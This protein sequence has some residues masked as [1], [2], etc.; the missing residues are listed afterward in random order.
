MICS[1]CAPYTLDCASYEASTMYAN[2]SYKSLQT[3]YR[4]VATAQIVVSSTEDTVVCSNVTKVTV[5]GAGFF[6]NANQ[7]SATFRSSHDVTTQ[8]SHTAISKNS[9]SELVFEIRCDELPFNDCT[10]SKQIVLSEFTGDGNTQSFSSSTM[11]IA[12]VMCILNTSETY[13]VLVEPNGGLITIQGYN[14]GS[15]ENMTRVDLVD[16]GGTSQELSEA[17]IVNMSSSVGLFSLVVQYESTSNIHDFNADA[18]SLF[19]DRV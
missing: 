5:R 7:Y 15:M 16:V 19:G 1:I 9:A 13:G 4:P 12:N 8:V 14:F 6:S 2:M 18:A 3:L 17:Q 11:S 10:E